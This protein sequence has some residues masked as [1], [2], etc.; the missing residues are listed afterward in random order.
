MTP[1]FG[2][3]DRDL[4]GQWV[5]LDTLNRVR[6][7]AIVGQCTALLAASLGLG[8]D[9]PLGLGLVVVAVSAASTIVTR[10]A[11][12]RS[13]RLSELEVFLTLLFDTTQL[14]LL[15]FLTGGLHN[16]FALLLLAPVTIAASTLSA[17]GTLAL[18]AISIVLAT[19][20]LVA[21]RP[22]LLPDGEPFVLPRLFLTGFWLA[23]LIGIVFLAVYSHAV[24]RER[25]ELVEALLATQ[26]ALSREQKLTDLGGVVAA[27]AHELGTPL[28]T[29]KLAASELADALSDLKGLPPDLAADLTADAALIREQADRCRAILRSM[30]QAGKQDRMLEQVPLEALLTEAIGPHAHRGRTVEI[31]LQPRGDA[32]MPEI[33]RRPEILHG[34]RNLIQNGVD[35]AKSTVRIEADWTDAQVRIAVIDDGPGYPAHQ[36]DRLGEPWLR[37]R[38][39]PPVAGRAEYDGMGL[40]LFIAK[41]LLERTG[42]RVQFANMAGA[43]GTVTGARAMVEW[44]LRAISAD[45]RQP[46]GANMPT[47]AGPGR[48]ASGPLTAD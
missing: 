25:H 4:Q 20:L 26:M 29:I 23:I 10:L 3:M 28:A 39:A 42:A 9:V 19:M 15:L 11:F 14:S 41:T 48:A 21:H 5:W 6:W 1:P 35:F 34:L 2:Q 13:R 17:R 27:A 24:A 30:G 47:D 44:P 36:I 7:L 32:R 38:R 18:G 31:V 16:P 12:P 43:D 37:N 45:G 46:L 22:I 8:L 40:G 33:Q